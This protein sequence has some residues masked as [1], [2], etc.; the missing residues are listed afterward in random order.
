M[1]H[2]PGKPET[3][4]HCAGTDYASQLVRVFLVTLLRGYTVE[5]PEQDHGYVWSR[6]TPDPKDGLRAR[7]RKCE[8]PWA[9][10]WLG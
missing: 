2:G 1:P 6:L 5:L 10:G 7:F 4:H 9:C 3:S 8:R